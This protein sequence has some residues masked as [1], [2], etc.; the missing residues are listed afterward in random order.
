MIDIQVTALSKEYIKGKKIL[1]GLTFQVDSGERVAL[2]GK[3]GAGKTTVLK[4]LMGEVRPDSGSATLAPGKKAGLISQIPLF[5]E[6]D[7]VE[8]VLRS[9]FCHL[10][11]MEEEMLRLTERLEDPAALRRYGELSQRFEALGGYETETRLQR[12]ANG[13]SIP[14][15]MRAQPFTTLSGGEKTRINLARLILEDTDILLLDEPTNHLDLSAIEWLQDYLS[16]Y[17]GTVLAVSHDRYFLDE[18]VTRVIELKAG[19]AEFYSGNY[20]FYAAERKRRYE[21]QLKRYEKEQSKV[22]QLEAAAQR[23]HLWAFMG[24]DKLHKTAFNIEKRIER[25]QVTERPREDKK[26]NLRFTQEDFEGDEVLRLEGLSKAFAERTLFSEVTL[27]VRGG[28]ERIALIGDNGT[29]KSTLLKILLKEEKPDSGTIWMGPSVHPAVLEQAVTFEDPN[30]T[31]VE[32]LVYGE[33]ANTVSEA[34][35]R[36]AAF[37]FRGEDVFKSVRDLSGGEQRR[38]ALCRLMAEKVNFLLLDEPTNHLDIDSCEWIEDAVEAFQGT[39]LFVSHD[40]YL[41][42]RFARRIWELK[43]GHITD[44]ACGYDE[45]L[46]RTAQPAPPPAYAKK[47]DPPPIAPERENRQAAKRKLTVLEHEIQKAEEEAALLQRQMEA[48]GSDYELWIR[49]DGELRTIRKDLTRLYEDWQVLAAKA[50]ES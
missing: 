1:D 19:R 46:R 39:L 6:G 20:T 21:E 50:E 12:V 5:P 3:N 17:K 29:G 49:K 44:Y 45:Y 26:L 4:I 8:D 47:K 27:K 22:T 40:R 42:R 38:L 14:E 18:V 33:E 36:L 10:V 23:L 2:L 16:T 13:L 7:T 9:A 11:R 32:T 28:G 37:G 24:N 35:N 41:I 15:A 48:C 31:L 30:R 43:D 34:R 25:L